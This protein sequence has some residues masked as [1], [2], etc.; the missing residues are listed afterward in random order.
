MTTYMTKREAGREIM[1]D[2][3][4]ASGGCPG[5]LR[6]ISDKV[7][8]QGR[9]RIKSGKIKVAKRLG[10]GF[11]GWLDDGEFDF[12][13]GEAEDAVTEWRS[14]QHVQEYGWT[15]AYIGRKGESRWVI[16][17]AMA[18]YVGPGALRHTDDQVSDL[19]RTKASMEFSLDRTDGRSTEG[20]RYSRAVAAIEVAI[21]ALTK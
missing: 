9:A 18:V 13:L 1:F 4:T 15:V 8:Q 3:L 21:D 16:E 5:T 7:T 11:R 10:R 6:E 17:D 2:L 14:P 20:K 12:A 19:L